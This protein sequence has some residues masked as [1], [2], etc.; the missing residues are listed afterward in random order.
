MFLLV[1]HKWTGARWP[2]EAVSY[3]KSLNI[4]DKFE[5]FKNFL[6]RITILTFCTSLLFAYLYMLF[7][8]K[9]YFLDSHPDFLHRNQ[10][11]LLRCDKTE[12]APC[13]HRVDESERL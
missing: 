4:A 13:F 7:V 5:G 12:Y 2:L 10:R 11:L 9:K 3:T 8:L 1:L 6:H